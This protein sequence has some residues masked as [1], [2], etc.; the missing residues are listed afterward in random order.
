[1]NQRRHRD[2]RHA[3]GQPVQPVRQVHR[4]REAEQHERDERQVDVRPDVRDV[5]K[6]RLL[7]ERQRELPRVVGPALVREEEERPP[8][9][10]RDGQLAEQLPA[11]LKAQVPPLRDLQVVVDEP[12]G[13][14]ARRGDQDDPDVE[15]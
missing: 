10:Q 1:V 14:E 15:A 4:V 8:H 2:D 6:R 12:D 9:E 13:G 3:D 5:L 7:E 11:P